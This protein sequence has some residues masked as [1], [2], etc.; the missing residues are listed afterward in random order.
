LERKF[1]DWKESS[2]TKNLLKSKEA[3]R[4][5]KQGIN[6]KIRE[7]DSKQ[8]VVRS[9][10][11]KNRNNIEHNQSIMS[12]NGEEIQNKSQTLPVE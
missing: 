10:K 2:P 6:E 1:K 12:S 8:T 7:S 4:Q 11:L 5:V 9:K 3:D